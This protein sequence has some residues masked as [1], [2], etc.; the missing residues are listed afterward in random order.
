MQIQLQWRSLWVILVTEQCELPCHCCLLCQ[1]RGGGHV[2]SLSTDRRSLG[3]PHCLCLGV[4]ILV[5]KG[6][7]QKLVLRLRRRQSLREGGQPA[8]VGLLALL[9]LVSPRTHKLRPLP[10]LHKFQCKK[11]RRKKGQVRSQPELIYANNSS[12]EA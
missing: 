4:C 5:G 6:D 10:F 11:K 9:T 12:A 8:Q 3:Y 2:S 7:I 1:L